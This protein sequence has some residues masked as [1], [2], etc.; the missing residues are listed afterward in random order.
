MKSGLRKSALCLYSI[1]HQVP[2]SIV[3]PACRGTAAQGREE[4]Y[5]HSSSY[6]LSIA[7]AN[8]MHRNCCS[9]PRVAREGCVGYVRRDFHETF[10]H[11]LRVANQK[12]NGIT[13][14]RLMPFAVKQK[15]SCSVSG[16]QFAAHSWSRDVRERKFSSRPE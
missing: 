1:G 15:R 14:L 16:Q 12:A 8:S 11:C 13:I 2:S 3:S 7:R 4:E 6:R 9:V 10:I 5:T